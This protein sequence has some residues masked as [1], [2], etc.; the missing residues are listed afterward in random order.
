MQP[1]TANVVLALVLTVAG[2]T[3]KTGDGLWDLRVGG[4]ARLVSE[5]GSDIALE[6]LVAAPKSKGRPRP[7]RDAKPQITTVTSGTR[8]VVLAL[9]GDDARVQIKDGPHAGSSYWI[10]CAKLEPVKP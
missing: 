8:V 9:D 1:K 4:E 2:C 5:E 7:N 3:T 6:S 10:P